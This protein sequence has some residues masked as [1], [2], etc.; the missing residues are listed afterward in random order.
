[1][2][3][4]GVLNMRKLTAFFILFIALFFFSTATYGKTYFLYYSNEQALDVQRVKTTFPINAKTIEETYTVIF[5]Q[6][7]EKPTIPNLYPAVPN[8]V[9]IKNITL[10]N[11]ILFIDF[12]DEVMKISSQSLES[13]F[14][15]AVNLTF[16][17]NFPEI[18]HIYY[19]VNGIRIDTLSHLDVS[20][21]FVRQDILK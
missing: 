9:Q 6:L 10:T 16:F 17:D 20:Q 21:G 7:K 14:I 13:V 12:N 1:M 3:K 15:K 19:T 8:S 4:N 5:N 2:G 11:G 18:K